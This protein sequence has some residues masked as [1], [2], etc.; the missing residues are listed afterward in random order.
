MEGKIIFFSLHIFYSDH[1]TYDIMMKSQI[2]NNLV[3]PQAEWKSELS[4]QLEIMFGFSLCIAL[5]NCVDWDGRR[6]LK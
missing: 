4:F 2:D 1:E 6:V 3:L 5:T